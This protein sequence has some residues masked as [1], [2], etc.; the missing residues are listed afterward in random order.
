MERIRSNVR[1][2]ASNGHGSQ[3]GTVV[4]GPIPDR[5]DAVWNGDG[6]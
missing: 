4:E 3:R 6:G 2:A 5:V 1:N